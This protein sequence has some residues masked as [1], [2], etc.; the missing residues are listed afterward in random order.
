M[1]WI[2][3]TKY[4]EPSHTI[5]DEILYKLRNCYFSRDSTSRYC[6]IP[7][8]CVVAARLHNCSRHLTGNKGT[9]GTRVARL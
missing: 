8:G 4:N 2:H 9:R 5:K 6:T 1:D 7:I 3:A